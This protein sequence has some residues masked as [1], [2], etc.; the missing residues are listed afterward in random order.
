MHKVGA[1]R[2]PSSPTRFHPTRLHP[3]TAATASNPRDYALRVFALSLG[4]GHLGAMA[5]E[6]SLRE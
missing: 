4:A 5:K 6:G 3:H 1:N 2:T